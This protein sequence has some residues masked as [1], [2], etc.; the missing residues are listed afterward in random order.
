VTSLTRQPQDSTGPVWTDD[1]VSACHVEMDLLRRFVTAR[2]N[3]HAFLQVQDFADFST[4][5]FDGISEWDAF[6]EHYK[7][8]ED[9]KK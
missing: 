9:C 2:P 6:R 8:C 4:S 1:D 5:A 3:D 7:T